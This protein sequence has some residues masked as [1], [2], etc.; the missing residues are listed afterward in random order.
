MTEDRGTAVR[1]VEALE[2]EGLLA[3]EVEDR[4]RE[5]VERALTE[6]VR[7]AAPAMPKLVEVVA[8]LGAALVLAAGFLFV[9][10]SW[11]DLGDM[12]Q[13]SFLTAVTL[14]LAVAGALT[15]PSRGAVG[16]AEVRRRL[17]GTL[18]TASALL[19]GVTVA[20]AME[21]FTDATF[22]DVYWP[23]VA[24]GVVLVAG[25]ATAYRFSPTAVGL[26]G[27]VGGALDVA[28]NLGSALAP[29]GDDEAIGVGI[30]VFTVG[31]AWLLLTELGLLDQRTIAR[32]LGS[33][34][35]VLGA[36]VTSFTG[37]T[38]WLGYL[39]S[40]AIA[41]AGVW[42]YLTRQDWPYLGAAVVAVT[43]VVPEAVSDWTNGSLGVV[44][45]VLLAGVT[46]LA[47]SLAGYRLRL[48]R[49][50]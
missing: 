2:A 25:A 29:S 14:V 26:V 16:N 18:L 7:E 11:D 30:A 49:A 39:M 21:V 33:V 6:P 37:D 35:A 24:A 22:S 12:G 36:Q 4:S 13:V 19:A 38:S 31:V 46:L 41:G 43:L 1:V 28:T 47:A 34:A 8:Y 9:L 40:A 17:S 23:G 50:R 10:R 15:V 44:G 27:M 42:L 20:V 32:T 48:R 3:P 5:V 45:G